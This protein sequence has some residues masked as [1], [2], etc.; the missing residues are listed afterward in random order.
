MSDRREFLKQSA[1]VAAALAAANAWRMTGGAADLLAAPAAAPLPMP[2]DATIT[3]LMMDALAAAKSA[4]A[5][6]A[7]VRIGRQRRNF[8]FT[9]EHQIQNVVD[10]DSL[11]CG[12]RALV[13]GAWGY[14]GTRVLTPDGVAA[15]AREAVGIA[16]ANRLARD[17]AVQLAP[18]P[19]VKNQTWQS[20]FTTDPFDVS[21]EEKAS[22]LLKANDEALKVKGVRFVFS[23]LF[24][25]KEERHY[26]N[27]DGSTTQQTLVRSWPLMQITAVAPDFSDFQNRG[28]VVPPMGRG[29]E[30]VLKCDLAGNAGKWGEEAVQKLSAKPV[31]VGKYD[32]V[33]HPS[34]LWLTIH[35]SI[36]HPTELDRALGYE[37]NYAGTSFVSPPDKVLGKLKY[38]PEFMNIQ[39]DRSQEGGLSTI[40]FDDEGVKPNDFLIIKNGIFND[41]QTTREQAMWLD[42]WYKSQ[43]IPTRSHGCSYAQGW[44]NVQFQRMPNVSL[45]PG[46]KDL[47][48]EDLIAATDRGIAI[49]GD[50]SFS[51]DQQRFNG[52]FGGQ[53]FWEIKGGKIVGMLKDVA[54]QMRTPDFW[55]SMDMIG[56]KRSYELGGSFFDG[57]G[58]PGQINAVSHGAVPARF[59]N[60]N[61][62]NTGRKA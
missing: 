61:V 48:Y 18:A 16:K 22:L 6:Y 2:D 34:H 46:E 47:M 53:T 29:W 51:I 27:S 7:D 30:Y 13:D 57:K 23:G 62:I 36:G 44:D 60:I 3:Q 42:W 31:E 14:G 20:A 35:E 15:A 11:G 19:V 43:K 10:T 24:F 37:A 1:Q 21:V 41:Y 9:R 17:Q 40:G 50:G 28:N 39:G 26:A 58:Q 8:V 38:G 45:L 56:G 33:L 32:L 52:Q 55:N 54:Y 49:I 59:R 12:V 4:G 25:V 5:A